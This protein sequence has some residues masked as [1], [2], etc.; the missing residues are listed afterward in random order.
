M[1]P[2]ICIGV[3]KVIRFLRRWPFAERRVALG[4]AILV[5]VVVVVLGW[6]GAAGARDSWSG[7]RRPLHLPKLTPGAACRVSRADP[8]VP[9]GRIHIFGGPGIGRGPVYPGLGAHSG[10][11]YATRDQQYG[12][13]WFGEK[14]FWYVLPSYR[15]PVLIRGRRLD[16]PG[17]MGFNGG[18]LPNPELRIRSDSSVSWAGQPAGSRGLPSGVRILMPGCYGF[19]IDGTTFSRVVVVLGDVVP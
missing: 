1:G 5:L 18:R 14:V 17:R 19:Q 8:R 4:M 2:T 3:M 15:G 7:L 13:K 6:A 11:L 10:L 16:G 9:W 12:S